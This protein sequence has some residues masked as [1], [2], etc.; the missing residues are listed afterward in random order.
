MFWHITAL[1]FR[2]SLVLKFIFD[3]SP[4]YVEELVGEKKHSSLPWLVC[5]GFLKNFSLRPFARTMLSP[6]RRKNL[7]PLQNA[8]IQVFLS[9]FIKSLSFITLWTR[10]TLVGL[11]QGHTVERRHNLIAC[12]GRNNKIPPCLNSTESTRWIVMERAMQCNNAMGSARRSLLSLALR[13]VS[14]HFVLLHQ[15][16]HL[17]KRFIHYLHQPLHFVQLYNTPI[18]M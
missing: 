6:K 3:L 16:L 5:H 8:A 1:R 18:R 7:L 14:R 13:A 11:H 9:A 15:I 4:F 12:G 2:N 17:C 10:L